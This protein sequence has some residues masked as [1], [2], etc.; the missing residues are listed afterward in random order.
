MIRRPGPHSGAGDKEGREHM[1][2]TV[3]KLAMAC[4]MGASVATMPA[5]AQS[6]GEQRP[7]I[8]LIIADDV[9]LDATTGM[10]PGIEQEML[11]AYG[12]EGLDHPG[13]LNIEGNPASTPVLDQLARDGM[14]FFNAWAQ[15]FCSPTRASL[16]TGLYARNTNVATYADALSQRH[17]S[18]VRDLAMDGSYVTAAFGK[19]HMAGL[20]SQNGPD[21][22][23]M[24]PKEAGFDLFVGNMHAALP[25]FWD[26]ETQ[27]QDSG[28]PPGEW[29]SYTA[30]PAE[31]PG[32]APSTYAAVHKGRDTID[33]IRAQEASDPDRPWFAW[34]A[35]NLAHATIIQQPSAMMIP[36]ADTLDDATRAE[37]D[38]CGGEYGTQNVGDC[39]PYA[40]LRAMT[41]SMDTIIG[42]VLDEVDRLD[43]NTIV[44]FVGDNGTPMYG[45]PGLDFIDNLYITREGRGK[46]S[47][48][49]SGAR[50]QLA[51]RG[52]GIAP[53]TSSDEITH[54]ADLFPTIL[55]LAGLAVPAEVANSDG[56]ASIPLDGVSIAP[57]LHGEAEHVRDPLRGFVITESTNLMR[58]G[59]M[60]VGVRNAGYKVVCV[61]D[62]G[63]CLLYDMKRDPLEEYPLDQPAS[64]P[65]AL[66]GEESSPGWSFCYLQDIAAQRSI[67]AQR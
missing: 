12:P 11:E 17:D 34:M 60:V 55:E 29:R 25:T 28:T 6:A 65:D 64:C 63:N 54:V 61:D 1:L 46:G 16:L 51:V 47:A 10:Y 37:I 66:A 32:I 62:A 50:V 53:G 42:R 33:W 24:K 26:Y 5:M 13:Y 27:M 7:N 9:G 43:P 57:I 14:V 59:Q 18:F 40:Q 45:R 3:S 41:N 48:F 23:G 15:P 2:H 4:A 36:N 44:I 58:D 22:P 38:A 19:W 35:F 30:G 52:P 31:L 20:P 21:Y 49:E 8:L 56:S 39:S 67:L